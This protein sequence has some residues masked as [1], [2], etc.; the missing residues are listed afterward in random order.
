MAGIIDTIKLA[1]VLVLAIPPALAGLS[2][3]ADGERLV[4]GALIG[5]AILLVLVEQLLT[6]PS[7]VPG[8][9]AKRVAGAVAKEPE[10]DSETDE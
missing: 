1:G 5:L 6:T 2:L 10:S 4:G 9:V 7:D 3:L 8:L